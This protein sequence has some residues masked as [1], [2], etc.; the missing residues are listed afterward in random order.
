MPAIG[1]SGSATRYLVEYILDVDAADEISKC[2]GG[3]VQ[4]YRGNRRRQRFVAPYAAKVLQLAERLRDGV[5]VTGLCEQR[6]VE[7]RRTGLTAERISD[8]VEQA[9]NAGARLHAHV[10]CSARLQLSA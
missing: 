4:V 1:S 3:G 2:L 7:L 6:C 8:D 5:L 10:H 9:L